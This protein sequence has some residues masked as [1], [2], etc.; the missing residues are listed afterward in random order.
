MKK[1]NLCGE[2]GFTLVEIL[3]VVAIIG[4]LAAIA[5]PQLAVHRKRGY[6]ATLKSDLGNAAIAEE[7]YFAQNQTYKVGTLS[8]GTPPGYNQSVDITSIT[9]AV[10]LNTFR[11]TATHANCPG[12]TW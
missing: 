3:V 5:I 4:V 12:I 7:S 1:L 9:A 6:E 10:G 2:P 8:S 11:V